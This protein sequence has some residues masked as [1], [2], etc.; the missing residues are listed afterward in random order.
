MWSSHCELL[1]FAKLLRRTIITY[2]RTISEPIKLVAGRGIYSNHKSRRMNRA[3]IELH[4]EIRC[5][6]LMQCD[7]CRCIQ[8]VWDSWASNEPCTCHPTSFVSP[9][10]ADRRPTPADQKSCSGWLM[11][12]LLIPADLSFLIG[13]CCCW[14]NKKENR[15]HLL[16]TA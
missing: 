4:A 2:I 11:C 14:A 8:V 7:P 13:Q 15:R 1:I 10:T 5:A 3:A 9:P 16:F 12:I 6:G